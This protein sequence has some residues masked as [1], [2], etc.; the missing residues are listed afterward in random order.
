MDDLGPMVVNSD[1]TLR[2]ITNWD[3][4]TKQEQANTLRLISARNKKRLAA[5]QKNEHPSSNPVEDGN[6]APSE[7]S[8]DA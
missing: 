3:S 4:M 6:E 5:L 2:R 8:S 1:G 7:R